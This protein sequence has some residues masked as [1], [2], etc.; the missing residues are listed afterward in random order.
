MFYSGNPLNIIT[1]PFWC[2]YKPN[3]NNSQIYY[4]IM[5][6]QFMNLLELISNWNFFAVDLGAGDRQGR[7]GRASVSMRSIKTSELGQHCSMV[8]KR[9]HSCVGRHR[10]RF[11]RNILTRFIRLGLIGSELGCQMISNMW[12]DPLSLPVSFSLFGCTCNLVTSFIHFWHKYYFFQTFIP[13]SDQ[14]AKLF[15][16]LEVS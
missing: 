5:L 12:R 3:D 8:A 7:K 11:L 4:I 6:L 2:V 10:W 1:W 14:S 15:N 9:A 13:L 16:L